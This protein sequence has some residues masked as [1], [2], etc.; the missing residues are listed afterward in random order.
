MD[1]WKAGFPRRAGAYL[2]GLAIG[3][4]VLGVVKS[5]L[6]ERAMANQQQAEGLQQAES[7][8]GDSPGQADPAAKGD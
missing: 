7:D 2:M 3:L 6:A 5:K 4:V 1:G 8:S